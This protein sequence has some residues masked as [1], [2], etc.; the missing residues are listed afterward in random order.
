MTDL[1]IKVQECKLVKS[2]VTLLEER[3]DEFMLAREYLILKNDRGTSLVEIPIKD[4]EF[5]MSRFI[6]INEKDYLLKH[7]YYEGLYVLVRSTI[8]NIQRKREQ[9][10]REEYL[11]RLAQGNN[12]LDDILRGEV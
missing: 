4:Q 3:G 2:L 9:V 1:E 12:D 8:R 11:K 10:Q 7:N 5:D 6:E